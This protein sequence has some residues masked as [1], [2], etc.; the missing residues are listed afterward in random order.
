MGAEGI[1][2]SIQDEVS[3]QLKKYED[4]LKHCETDEEK[5]EVDIKDYIAE[6]YQ[7]FVED[8][9]GFQ[10]MITDKKPHP[11]GFLLLNGDIRREIGLIACI[12]KT[13]KKKVMCACIDGATAEHYKYIKSD[14]LIVDVVGLTEDIWKRIGEESISNNELERRVASD[15]G[16]KTWDIYSKGYT[17]CINQCEKENT[18]KRVMRYKPTNTGEISAFVAGIRPGFKSLFNNFIDRKPYTTGVSQLDEVLKD[19]YHYM[20]YQESIMGFLNWLGIDMKET[21]DIVKKISKKIYLKHPEQMEELKEKCKEKWIEKVGNLDNKF[22]SAFQVTS[23]AGAYAFNASHSYCVGN[24][25]V[26]LAYLK[27]YYPYEFYECALNRYDKKKNKD[28]VAKLKSEMKEAF[29]IEVGE[30][31]FGLNNIEFTMD[32]EHNKI[33]PTLSAI[34]GMG[35]NVSKELYELSQSKHYDNFLDLII[36]IKEKTSTDNSMLEVLI[37][38]GYFDMFGKSKYLLDIVDIYNKYYSK[39]QFSKD[40]LPCDEEIIKKYSNKETVKLF[41]DIDMVGLMRELINNL[42]NEDIPLK[43]RLEVELDKLNMITYIDKTYNDNVCIITEENS[44]SYGTTFLTLYQINSGKTNTIKVDKRYFKKK[45]IKKFD[46]I[47]IGDIK[48]EDVKRKTEE[49]KFEPT[50]EKRLVLKSYGRIV[51]EVEYLDE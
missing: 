16:K 37:K 7:H 9:K 11:C 41:K 10:G 3:K 36:D 39:K 50:G 29:G 49:G 47:V 32:K 35:K 13:K 38:L 42:N 48:Q 28:K 19:S 33:N 17:C 1:E 25:G 12:S 24:D 51:D 27:A 44:N 31:K 18:T 8:S 21:Y 45:P 23:D 34:K 15:E 20:L 46:M 43:E 40:K 5:E 30:L 4:K 22:D 14:L 26:E 6:K 2:A